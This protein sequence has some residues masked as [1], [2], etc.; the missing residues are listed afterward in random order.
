MA[1][2]EKDIINE[3]LTEPSSDDTVRR[4]IDS[5]EESF[6]SASD[7]KMDFSYVD[8]FAIPKYCNQKDFAFAWI[9]LK[10][11]IQ[12]Y[13]ALEVGFFKIVN[14]MSSCFIGDPNGRDFRNHGGIE[15]QGMILVYRPKDLD[16]TMRT[17]SVMRHSEIVSS[18]QSGKDN[19][20]GYSTSFEKGRG[21]G[22]KIEVVAYEQA[23]EEGI[24]S[25]GTD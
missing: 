7:I 14:R 16:D 13:R 18:I 3:V 24:K 15:R 6:P 22:S 20:E 9:D 21:E 19:P 10:D 5:Q 8:P 4:M 17:V 23:G 11:D 2:T 1:K 25:V 12:R